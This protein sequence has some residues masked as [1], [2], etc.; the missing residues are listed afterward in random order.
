MTHMVHKAPVPAISSSSSSVMEDPKTG[1]SSQNND[2]KDEASVEAPAA[3]LKQ[4]KG[5]K[6]EEKGWKGVP[7]VTPA[8]NQTKYKEEYGYIVTNKR[9]KH[10]HVFSSP[11]CLSNS[12]HICHSSIPFFLM[13]SKPLTLNG[14]FVC[15][16]GF[17]CILWCLCLYVA[18]QCVSLQSPLSFWCCSSFG[19]PD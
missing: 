5:W 11:N 8:K 13:A 3:L 18:C 16:C 15:V 14:L 9:Y 10:C 17:L 7:S 19:G 1:G 6:L 4:D 12:L 2:I